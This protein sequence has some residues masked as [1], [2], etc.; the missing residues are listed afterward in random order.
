MIGALVWASSQKYCPE[1]LELQENPASVG[2]D[3][4]VDC[5]VNQAQLGQV[6]PQPILDRG[7]GVHPLAGQRRVVASPPGMRPSWRESGS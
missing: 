5:R 3:G 6:A 1:L 7:W 4:E 2:V